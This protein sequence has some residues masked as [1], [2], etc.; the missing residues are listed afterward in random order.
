MYMAVAGVY[1]G[2]PICTKR[3]YHTSVPLAVGWWAT[4]VFVIIAYFHHLYMDFV[5]IQA[6]QFIGEIASYLAAVPVLVITVYGGVML[7]H[8]SGMKWSLGSMFL[9]GGM[10]G[11]VVGGIAA[12]LDA[13]IP[14]NLDLH[15][16]LWVPGHFHTYLLEGVLLFILGWIF[17]NLE[18]R[19]GQV[20]SLATRWII[21]L[22]TFGGGALFLL[23]FY[24]AGASGVPRRYAAEPAPGPFWAGMATIGATIFL[25]GLLLCAFEAVRLLRSSKREVVREA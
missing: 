9:F 4:L 11:W 25:I 23:A 16:T 2:L 15:N 24:V 21:G 22:F 3:A 13:T 6:L 14:I 17:V 20:S 18:E 12:V 5:Q 8:R 7:L 19:S 10:V 1:V